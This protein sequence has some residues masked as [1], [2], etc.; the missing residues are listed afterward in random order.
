MGL[1]QYAFKVRKHAVISDTQFKDEIDNKKTY[2]EIYYWRKVP[3]LQG[4]M[5][6]LYYEKGGKNTF[7]CES[8]RLYE[9]DLDKLKYAVEH[10]EMPV[11]T[12]GFFFGNHSE[13]DMPSILKFVKIA[14]KAIK[15]GNAVYYSS[16]W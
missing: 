4:F 11:N 1:D 10:N 13:E 15:E 8:I 16:W 6:K 2:E 12:I 7:N 14:K 9:E 5:E 3:A